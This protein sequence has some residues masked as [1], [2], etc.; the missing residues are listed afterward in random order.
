MPKRT[1][2]H[3]AWL[4]TQLVDPQTA[5]DYINDAIA[6]SPEMLPKVLRYVAE[7]KKISR[8][9]EYAKLNRESLYR[10]LSNEGNPTFRTLSCVLGAVGLRIFVAPELATEDALKTPS[11]TPAIHASIGELKEAIIFDSQA[12]EHEPLNCHQ[13][14]FDHWTYSWTNDLYEPVF[15]A[16]GTA[17]S[18][19]KQTPIRVFGPIIAAQPQHFDQV[20]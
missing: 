6:E 20:H 1:K 7:A 9:A 3:H 10:A 18:T 2:S 13:T 5:A 14:R 8:V 11:A 16:A 4:L 12:I 17:N 15:Q 19:P